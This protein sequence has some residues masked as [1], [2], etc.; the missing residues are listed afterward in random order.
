LSADR[1]ARKLM[2]NDRDFIH[3]LASCIKDLHSFNGPE[4]CKLMHI[5][6]VKLDWRDSSLLRSIEPIIMDR[7]SSLSPSDIVDCMAS[8]S[9]IRCGSRPF[10]ETMVAGVTSMDL[11]S[12]DILRLVRMIHHGDKHFYKPLLVL[13]SIYPQLKKMLSSGFPFTTDDLVHITLA[14]TRW[15]HAISPRDFS[16][17][18]TEI[19]GLIS[20][21]SDINGAA[22]IGYAI[23]SMMPLDSYFSCLESRILDSKNLSGNGVYYALVG[24]YRQSCQST[25]SDGATFALLESALSIQLP[26]I[27]TKKIS[28]ICEIFSKIFHQV[29]SPTETLVNFG[30]SVQRDSDFLAQVDPILVQRVPTMDLKHLS[31]LMRAYAV[32][33]RGSCELWSSMTT[34][35]GQLLA[36]DTPDMSPEDLESILF[37]LTEMNINISDDVKN[38]IVIACL[39]RIHLMRENFNVLLMFI[40]HFFDGDERNK[41]ASRV[42]ELMDMEESKR[43]SVVFLNLALRQLDMDDISLVDLIEGTNED[44]NLHFHASKSS[45]HPEVLDGLETFLRM[46]SFACEPDRV[47]DGLKVDYVLPEIRVAVIVSS[48]RELIGQ[49][50]PTGTAILRHRAV[51]N[52]GLRVFNV[53]SYDLVERG[54]ERV[55]ED[56]KN[57]ISE[58]P[59]E[60]HEEEIVEERYVEKG[61]EDEE[62]PDPV[63]PSIDYFVRRDRNAAHRARAAPPDSLPWVPTVMSLKGRRR[64]R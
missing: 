45:I 29:N 3:F 49:C 33:R 51:E 44:V 42:L 28:K 12:E 62:N 8:F 13:Q 25:Q 41:L 7:L 32:C 18:L 63:L 64:R 43:P 36:Q 48:P 6:T 21:D 4:L 50:R 10:W 17:L 34:V 37:A 14:Y 23:S 27:G 24:L 39:E 56:L 54:S 60:I 35:L 61:L 5:T 52:S 57:F 11:S 19:A 16:D 46:T 53:N 2:I 22:R 58:S 47:V 40:A 15:D 55:I 38:S 30:P 59:T 31:K 26:N 20:F 1:T 9:K